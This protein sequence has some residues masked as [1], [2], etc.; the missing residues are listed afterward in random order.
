MVKVIQVFLL[1]GLIT[2]CACTANVQQ[3]G[4][5]VVVYGDSMMDWNSSS[6]NSTPDVLEKLLGEPVQNQAVKGARMSHVLFPLLDIRRQSIPGDWRVIIVNGGAND[7]L[8]ECACGPCSRNLNRLISESGNTGDL[9]DFL[10]KLRDTGAEVIFTGYHRPRQIS[11]PVRGCKN[12]VENLERRVA[13]F[14]D[15]QERITFASMAEAFPIGD[16]SFYDFDR[17]HPS[18]KG[19]HE[20]AKKLFP[21]VVDALKRAHSRHSSMS[22]YKP[23]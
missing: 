8:F 3:E 22:F 13:R 15:T 7:M 21:Y 5:R 14:A 1:L 18:I 16:T 2:F 6:G 20:L 19:S 23:Q 9:P 4:A 12:E 11:S 17:I 10:K